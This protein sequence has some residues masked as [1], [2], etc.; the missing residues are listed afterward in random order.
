MKF[1]FA[2]FLKT[3][4]PYKRKNMSGWGYLCDL[5]EPLINRYQIKDRNGEPYYFSGELA[6]RL[7]SNKSDIPNAI[8]CKITENVLNDRDCL[9][10]AETVFKKYIGDDVY[11]VSNELFMAFEADVDVEESKK[12]EAKSRFEM[13]KYYSLLWFLL[14][15]ASST[16]NRRGLKAMK[17]PGRPKKKDD[18]SF[19]YLS[20]KEKED[21]AS[22]FIG[23]LQ[24]E[25]CRLT[26]DDLRELLEII[27]YL[28]PP[29]SEETKVQISTNFLKNWESERGISDS[30]SL[31]IYFEDSGLSHPERKK[32]FEEWRNP[33]E[34]AYKAVLERKIKNLLK[35][36]ISSGDFTEITDIFLDDFNRCSYFDNCEWFGKLLTKNNF[37]LPDFKGHICHSLWTY[38]HTIAKFCRRPS[39]REPFL[40]Y[41]ETIRD[42]NSA[43]P[44]IKSRCEGLID[45]CKGIIC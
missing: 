19:F 25:N 45:K 33:I 43:D 3:T 42:E 35:E 18:Y 28:N 2:L 12:H 14:C 26:K 44:T 34:K 4:M 36:S 31:Y 27:A 39:L 22:Y 17:K 20:Q 7:R 21:R 41:I 23:H 38:C 40:S 13:Q 6:S 32:R 9:K 16:S 5:F 8:K 11:R 15:Y 29:I 10:N 30:E 37:F 24:N 1:D